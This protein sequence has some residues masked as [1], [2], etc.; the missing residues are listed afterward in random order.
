MPHEIAAVGINISEKLQVNLPKLVDNML[1]NLLTV[2][3]Y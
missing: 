1:L 3:P 2:V